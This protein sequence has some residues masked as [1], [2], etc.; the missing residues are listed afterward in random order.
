[1]PSGTKTMAYIRHDALTHGRKATYERFVATKRPH[2]TE[3]KRVRPTVGGNLIRYPVKVSTPSADLTTVKILLSSVI[4]TPHAG[5]ATFDLTYF[6]LGAPMVRKEYMRIAITSIH[7]SIINQYH[8]LDLVHNGFVLVAISHCMYGLPQAGILAYNQLV[9]H[10]AQYG[11]APCTHTPGLWTHKT[12]DITFYLV[13]D[14]FGIKYTN[15]CDTEHLLTALQALNVVTTDWTGSLYLTMT[16]DWDYHNHTVDISMPGYFTK[17][18]DRFQHNACGRAPHYPH[19]WTKPQ[20][21]SHP[22]LTP[23]PDDTDLLPT[24]TLTR[25]QEIV[26]T[27]LFYGRAIDST[28]LVA[29]GTISSQQS[30]GTQATA[31][32]LTQLLNYA[33][34]HPD[35]TVRYHASDMY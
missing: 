29:L 27:L 7:Q 1:M 16:I 25:I 34:A 32:A 30:K 20:Y 6:Y 14:D 3:K 31:H 15:R 10:L 24:S 28:M 12:R 9:T 5:F 4:S 18:L 19:A 21:G 13:V 33:A 2:K 22:Q 26:G 35:A 11:Y 23:T 17:A 8:L